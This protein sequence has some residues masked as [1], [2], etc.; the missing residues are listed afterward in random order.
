M[1][2]P[3]TT[4]SEEED[5][6][7]GTGLASIHQ[8]LAHPMVLVPEVRY[9]AQYLGPVPVPQ[10]EVVRLYPPMQQSMTSLTEILG[11]YEK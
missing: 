8:H 10:E 3:T 4:L 2:V 1:E 6:R 11:S 5:A 7:T 9:W